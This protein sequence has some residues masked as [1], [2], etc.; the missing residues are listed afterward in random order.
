MKTNDGFVPITAIFYAVFHPIQGTKIVHQVPEDAIGGLS[1]IEAQKDVL[2]N[3]DTVK[4]YIIPKSQLCNRLVSFKIKEYRVIG[5]PVNIEGSWYARNSFNFNFCFVF[6]YNANTVPY[7]SAIARMGKMFQAL[8]EQSN[9][10]SRLDKDQIFFSK[11]HEKLKS[12]TGVEYTP[13]HEH[14]QKILLLS[15]ESLIN[16][17]YQDLNNYSECCI[18]ID[19]ATSVDI[20]LFPI[21]PPPVDLKA[22]Q[23]PILTVKLHL[24]DVTCDPTMI[25]ILPFINGV[26]SVQKISNLADVDYALTK[27][28]VQHLMHYQC[29]ILVDIF[30]FSN[31]YAPTNR[32]GEFL[33]S[34]AMAEEC[35][36]YVVSA[37]SLKDLN[38]FLYTPLV[39]PSTATPV[40]FS[41]AALSLQPHEITPSSS[42]SNSAQQVA[43]E[44]KIPSKA[45]LFHLYRLLGQGQM[46]K[47]WYIQ[48]QKRLQ[49]IDIRRFINFG[50]VKGIIYRVH[51][52]PVLESTTRALENSESSNEDVDQLIANL[53]RGVRRS[54]EQRELGIKTVIIERD[55]RGMPKLK[56]SVSFTYPVGSPRKSSDTL[57][58]A[59]LHSDNVDLDVFESDSD[60]SDGSEGYQPRR[61]VTTVLE[62]Y[63][64]IS[65]SGAIE[66][67]RDIRKLAS[68]VKNFEHFDSI[69]TQLEKP[70]E[71]VERLLDRFGEYSLI[72]A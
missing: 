19:S 70:R 32:I 3:F 31:I 54:R 43:I 2:F 69:C 66:D 15:I 63:S 17:V 60:E 1:E 18:P 68:L 48:H 49:N 29:I 46:L 28:C 25:R 44:I 35:Q 52:Y 59:S 45:R 62:T 58:D 53:E 57:S 41:L 26:N 39:H 71:E 67:L 6:P 38:L 13:G 5:F 21:L 51:T 56:R 27:Q 10:L 40:N 47:E 55:N 4:N 22:H 23:V 72:N 61:T 8:E 30:Q 24:F 36:A 64:S 7:E 16:Q 50:V 20:K 14:I 12:V 9:L 11:D 33:R 65:E 42:L 37:N 34:K